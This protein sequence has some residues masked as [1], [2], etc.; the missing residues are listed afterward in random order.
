LAAAS[1]SVACNTTLGITLPDDGGTTTHD[2]GGP[3]QTLDDGG[4][5]DVTVTPP[6]QNEAGS[7]GPTGA[8]AKAGT[9]A[10]GDPGDGGGASDADASSANACG[11]NVDLQTDPGN[12]GRCSHDCGGATCVAGMCSAY[13]VQ[14]QQD[15]TTALAVDATGI[16]WTSEAYGGVYHCPGT[17]CA[18]TPTLLTGTQ[19]QPW[20]LALGG[21]KVYWE[22]DQAS[23]A[24]I[25]SSAVTKLG[26]TG[27]V[28]VSRPTV[29]RA[30]AADDNDVFWTESNG[31]FQTYRCP[32][33]GCDDGGIPVFSDVVYD[34]VT[35]GT[36][37]VWAS[38]L[39]GL[40]FCTKANCAQQYLIQSGL[41]NAQN[42][43]LHDGVAYVSDTG[44][45][46]PTTG[47][48]S[49]CPLNGTNCKPG[50]FAP[51]LTGPRALA[52]D[53]SGVYWTA[54]ESTDAGDTNGAI[55]MCPLSGCP[56]G[57]PVVV[58][59]GQ[60]GGVG[61]LA[62]YGNLVFF[63]SGGPSSPYIMAVVKP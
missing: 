53:D 56:A 28:F 6:S 39:S 37:L 61:L 5:S 25:L 58:A 55:F 52:V 3:P 47:S 22:A 8:D 33:T 57:G 50:N 26:P 12:C 24:M 16:Y 4:A 59:A 2:E 51:S 36:H 17:S 43:A 49:A 23:G 13:V 10:A 19:G 41:T 35:D 32:Q 54:P 42:V 27:D 30:L 46:N 18:A 7:D 62:V 9:D 29:M 48:I 34:L 20:E 14:G 40:K 11:G 1:L 60:T 31:S 38:N 63:T 21:G 45:S 15:Y 44:G